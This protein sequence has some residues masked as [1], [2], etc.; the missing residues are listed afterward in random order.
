[1]PRPIASVLMRTSE[2]LPDSIGKAMYAA[3]AQM[4]PT[5]DR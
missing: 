1:M 5:I 3:I 2:I 4:L